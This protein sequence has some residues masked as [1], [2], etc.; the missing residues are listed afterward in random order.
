MVFDEKM[1]RETL[2]QFLFDG[3]LPEYLSTQ[4]EENPKCIKKV[5]SP[6]NNWEWYIVEG[7]EDEEIFFGFVFGSFPEGG[8]FTLA[9]LVSAFACPIENYIPEDYQEVAKRGYEKIFNR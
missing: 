1:H 4:E 5:V 7:S 9:D 6:I 8:S 2:R 3:S